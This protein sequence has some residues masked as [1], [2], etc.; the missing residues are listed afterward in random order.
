V[1]SSAAGLLGDQVEALVEHYEARFSRFRVDSELY[2]LSA[3]AGRDVTVSADLFEVLSAALTYWQETAGLFDPLILAELETAGYD[4]TFSAVPRFQEEVPALGRSSR[5]VFGSVALDEADRRV[6][7]PAGARLDLGGIAKGWIIDRLSRLL[8]PHGPHLID[9]GGDMAA[10]GAGS[11]GGSGWLIAVADPLRLERDLCW[12]RLVDAAIATSTTMRRRW[13]LGG[14]WLHH[15]IDPRTGAP[16]ASDLI[17]V[18]VVAPT[19]A[20]ADV[21]AKT[22]L[23]LGREA[24]LP[25]LTER[26]LPALLVTDDGEVMRS[27]GWERLEAPVTRE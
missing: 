7:L 24:A 8:S 23:I 25:W 4:R 19:A 14:R 22:G 13:N 2:Q 3:L 10:R 21:Y 17:Q 1:Y 11:D 27:P 9:V 12:L 18:T 5:P 15:I 16:A 26:S 20:A 6:R